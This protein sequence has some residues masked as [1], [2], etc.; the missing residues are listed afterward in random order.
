MPDKYYAKTIPD[1]KHLL[2]CIN[3][4]YPG[5]LDKLV[6]GAYA[7]RHGVEAKAKQDETIL[8]T[9]EWIAELNALPFQSK[10]R[11]KKNF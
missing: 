9:D 11:P 7:K 10:V 5:F 2:G 4:I 1:R 6:E 8:A 3:T